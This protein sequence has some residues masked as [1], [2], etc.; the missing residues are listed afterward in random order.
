[1]DLDVALEGLVFGAF[2]TLF[3]VTVFAMMTTC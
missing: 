1:M 2:L 3:V